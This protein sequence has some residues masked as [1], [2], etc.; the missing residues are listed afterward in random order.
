MDRL[1]PEKLLGEI[2]FDESLSASNQSDHFVQYSQTMKSEP[3]PPP[4]QSAFV[5]YRNQPMISLREECPLNGSSS[6]TITMRQRM[7]AFL[8]KSLPVERNKV[9][10]EYEKERCFRH[11]INER[12][13]RQ[14][15]REGCLALH[16]ILPRGT[17]TDTNS[18]V[19]V[20]AKEIQKLQ[21]YREELQRKN[22]VLQANLE[23]VGRNIAGGRKVQY[24]RVPLSYPESGI[25]SMIETL[26]CLKGKGVDTRSIKSKFSEEELLMVLE[27]EET[28]DAFAGIVNLW[29]VQSREYVLVGELDN[30]LIFPTVVSSD[31]PSLCSTTVGCWRGVAAI[32]VSGGIGG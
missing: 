4:N 19:Q 7:I 21:G 30:P 26:K 28:K 31:P 3:F 18:V 17:K 22:L 2:F 8:K 27:I 29:D 12:M 20:A 10:E 5:Q 6:Q 13:R 24:L 32:S 11:M 25:D 23:K 1:F 14:R 9:A 16:S 15:Q